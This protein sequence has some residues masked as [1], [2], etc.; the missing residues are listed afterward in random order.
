[1]IEE[2]F[3][4]ALIE[5]STGDKVDELWNEIVQRYSE[6][7]RHYHTLDHLD[8]MVAELI[9]VMNV[10]KDRSTTVMAIAYHDIVYDVL[11]QDNEEQSAELAYQRLT[12]LQL[13]EAQ[14]EACKNLILATINYKRKNLV[15]SISDFI[16]KAR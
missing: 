6:P 12:Q 9:P 10:I 2:A 3:R 11:K 5:I 7:H 1:M 14:K 13:P 15:F 16:I 4:S 8:N